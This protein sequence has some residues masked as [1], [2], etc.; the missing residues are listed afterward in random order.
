MQG[1]LALPRKIRRLR[2]KQ[3]VKR[4]SRVPDDVPQ[5]IARLLDLSRKAIE[6]ADDEGFIAARRQVLES[7]DQSEA[8]IGRALVDL[9]IAAVDRDPEFAGQTGWQAAKRVPDE[10]RLVALIAKL[11]QAGE[12]SSPLRIMDRAE[13][14]LMLT[15]Q[16]RTLFARIRADAR[17][18]SDDMSVPQ[19]KR[20]ARTEGIEKVA[21]VVP[22]RWKETPRIRV[23]IATA[24]RAELAVEIAA[25]NSV[26]GAAGVHIFVDDPFALYEQLRVLRSH[27][28]PIAIDCANLPAAL[29]RREDSQA[30]QA[31]RHRL[32][33]C[34]SLADHVI[35]RGPSTAALFASLHDNVI[36]VPDLTRNDK[37]PPDP[38]ALQVAAAE[39]GI[40]EYDS[41]AACLLAEVPD[42]GALDVLS[43][44]EEAGHEGAALLFL[45]DGRAI[46]WIQQE[47]ARL[48]LSDNCLFQELPPPR[49][50]RPLMA[51]F[52]RV[53]CATEHEP[54]MGSVVPMLL[55]EAAALGMPMALSEAAVAGRTCD[56]GDHLALN[57]PQARERLF[58]KGWQKRIA[59]G[60]ERSGP[61][62]LLALYAGWTGQ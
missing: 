5:E 24:Q 36:E 9:A 19:D 11:H 20:A 6:W 13:P 37:P 7:R 31:E 32:A 61:D 34:A 26:G 28:A 50:W 62:P 22:E 48:G 15:A 42:Q 12:V 39:F 56:L 1:I 4:K 2:L 18:L 58:R 14:A 54:G 30:A 46:A 3:K 55:A 33:Q 8:A 23:A 51:A 52:D 53:I 25:V 47:T 41:V 35:V 10:H 59:G 40:D 29:L 21:L 27:R 44:F 60:E 17:L 45:G 16:Q 43:A 38:D 49:R 57:G